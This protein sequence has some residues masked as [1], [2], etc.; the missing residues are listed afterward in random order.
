MSG[1]DEPLLPGEQVG[2]LGLGSNVGERR[3]QL[4]L[5]VD[6]LPAHGVRVLRSSAVYDTDPVGEILDQPSFLNACLRIATAL[7]PEQLL[8]ACKAVEREQGRSLD[9]ADG[10]VR[11]GPRPIDVDLLLLGERPYASERLT[12]PHAQVGERRFVLVPL[13]ELDLAL[14][15]P[16]GTRLADRLA[17]LPLDEGVRRAGDP[18]DV[19]ATA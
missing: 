17:A 6:A 7:E 4:Q 11:H 13:L 15:L 2:Y 19:A 9:P 3:T 14:T 16:D 8:A 10:Y 1:H 18:L 5:A 12:L